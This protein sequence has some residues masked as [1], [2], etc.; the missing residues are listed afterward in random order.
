VK[1]KMKFAKF[2]MMMGCVILTA[3]TLKPKEPLIIYNG[4]YE[5]KVKGLISYVDVSTEQGELVVTASWD[6]FKKPLGYLNGDSFIFKGIG[7]G[8]TFTRNPKHLID[9][10]VMTG[11]RP[12]K[13]INQDSS[14]YKLKR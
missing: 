4:R 5:Q 10:F 2:L 13:K 9:G 1:F 8:I 7:F 3:C 12:W 11:S 6:K 14:F